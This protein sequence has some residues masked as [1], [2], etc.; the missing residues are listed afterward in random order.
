[1]SFFSHFFGLSVRYSKHPHI[2]TQDFGL[3][4]DPVLIYRVLTENLVMG[5][6]EGR[7]ELRDKHYLFQI[8]QYTGQTLLVDPV[9]LEEENYSM[10]PS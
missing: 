3:Q 4:G 9:A 10:I 8:H 7:V 6:G 2:R 5:E 1:M